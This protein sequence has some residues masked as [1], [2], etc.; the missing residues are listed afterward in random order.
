MTVDFFSTLHKRI[1]FFISIR[2][3]VITQNKV[4]NID[5][6]KI[7]WMRSDFAISKFCPFTKLKISKKMQELFTY[8]F[9]Y[10]CMCMAFC[11]TYTHKT[12]FCNSFID[13]AFVNLATLHKKII[14]FFCIFTEFFFCSIL[15]TLTEVSSYNFYIFVFFYIFKNVYFFTFLRKHTVFCLYKTNKCVFSL[16]SNAV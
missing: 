12:Y 7:S 3:F 6:N 2:N 13:G 11:L 9:L 16:K 1:C 8:F 14:G 5:K 15:I 4:N 10:R